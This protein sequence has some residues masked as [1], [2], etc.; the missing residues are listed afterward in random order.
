MPK[1]RFKRGDRVIWEF[2]VHSGFYRKERKGIG[3]VLQVYRELGN[4]PTNYKVEGCSR[5]MFE[6]ELRPA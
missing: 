2:Q 6:D 4:M 3:L 1:P 5:V